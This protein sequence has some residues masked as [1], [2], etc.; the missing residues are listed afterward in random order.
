MPQG[1]RGW[2]A[3][4]CYMTTTYTVIKHVFAVYSVFRKKTD[5]IYMIIKISVFEILFPKTL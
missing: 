1:G 5:T 3:S 4:D 2:G